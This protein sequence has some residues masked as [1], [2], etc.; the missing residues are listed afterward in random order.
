MHP[1]PFQRLVR[2]RLGDHV[3]ELV[4]RLEQVVARRLEDAVHLADVPVDPGDVL[5]QDRSS[6]RRRMSRHRTATLRPAAP[7]GGCPGTCSGR[8]RSPPA[9]YRCPPHRSPAWSARRP[10]CRCHSR[11]PASCR[12]ASAGSSGPG[13]PGSPGDCPAAP[14]PG[15][16]RRASR[17]RRSSCCSFSCS[18]VE[19]RHSRSSAWAIPSAHLCRNRTGASVRQQLMVIL[20]EVW[21]QRLHRLVPMR[22]GGPAIRSSSH[23]RIVLAQRRRAAS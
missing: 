4:R 2:Q 3:A 7:P 22:L 9:R 19:L 17:R 1:A 13:N 21:P 10:P 11:S 20:H 16:V 15:R 12:P 8:T 5:E 14:C 6:A 23:S 18:S